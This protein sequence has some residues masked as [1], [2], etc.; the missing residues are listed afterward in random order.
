MRSLKWLAGCLIWACTSYLPAQDWKP[1]AL[2]AKVTHVQPMTGIVLWTSNELVDKTPIQLEFAYMRYDQVVRGPQQYDWQALDN[3]LQ[4]VADRKHQLILRWYDTYV[5]Q[6]N[7]LPEYLQK[8]PG[9]RAVT[10][11]SEGKPTGFPDWS[12]PSVQQFALDFFE[13]FAARYDRDPRLAFVQVGFG[14]WSE[15]HIYDG[16]FRLGSTF[17]SQ[18]YQAT[19]ARHLSKVLQ[20]SAWMIS[21]DAADNERAPYTDDQQL[22]ALPFGLFDDS[23]NHA[24]HAQENEP[25]WRALGWDR[26][27][28]A[29]VGGEFAFFEKADQKLALAPRG[30]HGIPFEKQAAKFHVSFMIGDDQV[31]YQNAER[32]QQASLA[33]GYRFRVLSLETN[34]QQTRA[35][36]T[37]TGVAPIYYDAY[38]AMRGTR[39][40]ESLKHLLPGQTKEFTIPSDGRGSDFSISC[41]RLTPGQHIQ[42][43]AD[44]PAR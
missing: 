14:L 17:P 41:D 34:G 26:W 8:L 44:L 11:K 10:A 12:Q 31:N 42:F 38:P 28:R 2:Q 27:Q 35:K 37:N 25:N 6:P 5:G 15:Y 43:E 40:Q 23:F 13:Q 4:E 9:Y 20:Q 16:P 3:L 30:P 22:L 36:L 7:G 18:A 1:L 39:A 19:F 32:I 29:P 21:V 24:R 33:C